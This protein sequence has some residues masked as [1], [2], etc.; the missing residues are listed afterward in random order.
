VQTREKIGYMPQLFALY[1]ELSVW[2]N[3]NF[4]ASIYGVRFPR[5]QRFG[6][7]LRFVELDAHQVKSWLV[8][9][10]GE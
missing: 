10:P 1:P 5:K 3:L 4:A 7:L 6:E 2:E 8:T 9:S